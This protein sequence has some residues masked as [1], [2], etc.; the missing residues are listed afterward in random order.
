MS[1]Q[2]GR[3]KRGRRK[4]QNRERTAITGTAGAPARNEREARKFNH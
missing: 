4:A 1:L 3:R 2:S